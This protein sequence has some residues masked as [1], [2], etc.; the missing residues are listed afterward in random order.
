MKR[1]KIPT[2]RALSFL[3]A[4]LMLIGLCL[5]ACEGSGS[6]ETT[7]PGSSDSTTAAPDST[8][9]APETTV[10]GGDVAKTPYTVEVVSE[11]G[12]KLKDI[13]VLIYSDASLTV[14][15]GY[16]KTDENGVAS[17]SLPTGT[18]SYHA[19]LTEVPEGYDLAD[20]YPL[21]GSE[22][23]VTLSSSLIPE[24]NLAGTKFKLGDIMHD[25]TVKTVDGET[26]NLAEALKTKKAVLINFWYINCSWCQE[27]FPYMNS[28]Y[29]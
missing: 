29:Q 5:T 16:A 19:V 7:A 17:F 1:I 22:T 18:T 10:S 14:M 3:L 9:S 20:S 25:F 15:N 27:E 11:G 4:M 2:T 12:L 23:K 21:A 6:E 24:G 8:T 26:F 13:T 28:V